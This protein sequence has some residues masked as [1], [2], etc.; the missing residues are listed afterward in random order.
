MCHTPPHCESSPCDDIEFIEEIN[1]ALEQNALDPF[2][3]H[4]LIIHYVSQP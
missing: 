2:A 1:E 3:D 4:D